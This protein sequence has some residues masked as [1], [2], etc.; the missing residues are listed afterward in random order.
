MNLFTN[1]LCSCVIHRE[2]QREKYK[3]LESQWLTQV[4]SIDAWIYSK[5]ITIVKFMS[6][7]VL[8][9]N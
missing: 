2:N 3:P 5:N 7:Q 1:N 8:T 9:Q 4:I 6:V